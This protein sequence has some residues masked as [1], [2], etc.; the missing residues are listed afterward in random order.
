[1]KKR[2]GRVLALILA[3]SLVMANVCAA[4]ATDSQAGMT[5]S[6]VLQE[7]LQGEVKT[8][9]TDTAPDQAEAVDTQDAEQISDNEAEPEQMVENTEVSAEAVKEEQSGADAQAVTE[10]RYENE[11]VEVTVSAQSEGAIPTGAQL[12][13]VPITSNDDATKEQYKEVKEHIQAKADEEEKGIAGFLAYDITFVDAQGNEIEPNGEVKVSIDYKNATL[14]EGISE[15]D[16]KDTNVTVY[17][18]E[19]DENGEVKEVVDMSQAD[20]KIRTME[21]TDEKKVEKVEV[22]TESFSTFTIVWD[23]NN[24]GSQLRVTAHYG[25]IND[26]G[27]WEEIPKD[28]IS[29]FPDN[30]TITGPGKEIALTS[31][32]KE[33]KGY[34]FK[35]VKVND[36]NNGES[37]EKLVTSSK[38]EWWTTKYYI[39]YVKKGETQG[40]DWLS[41]EWNGTKEGDIYFVYSKDKTGLKIDSEHIMD[42]G[43]MKAVYTSNDGEPTAVSYKWLES[44]KRDGVYT[45]VEQLIFTNGK[46]NVDGDKLYPAYN[47]GDDKNLRKW[48]KVE[49]TLSDKTTVISEP[50]QVP[51]YGQLQNGG[52]ETPDL[53]KATNG[54]KNQLSNLEMLQQGGVWQTTGLGTGTD[55]DGNSRVGRDIEIIN[56]GIQNKNDYRWINDWVAKAG[57]QF[58][59]LNCEAAGALYQ[60]VLT[61]EGSSLNYWLSHRA[62]GNE[63]SKTPEYDTMYLV[64]MP[65][66]DAQNLKTQ[67][68]LK[69]YLT[70]TLG[71]SNIGQKYTQV[72]DETLYNQEGV[73]VIRVT[74]NDQEWHSLDTLQGYVPTSDVTRFFFMAGDTA[75][76]NSTVGNFLDEV[77][78][79][80]ELPPVKEDEFTFELEKNFTGLDNASIKMVKDQIGFEITAENK[81]GKKLSGK[82]LQTLFGVDAGTQGITVEDNAIVISGSAMSLDVQG[83]KI[84]YAFANQKIGKNTSYKVT[85]KERNAEIS[86]YKLTTKTQ[87]TVTYDGKETQNDDSTTVKELKGKTKATVTYTNQYKSTKNKTVNFTKIWDDADNKFFT[88]PESLEVTLT[89]SI[90]VE[91]GGKIVEKQVVKKKATVKAPT[92]KTSWDVPVYEDYNGQQVPI[93]YK[94]TEGD[95]GGDYVYEKLNN[96]IAVGGDG[97]EYKKHS[98]DGVESLESSKTT[99]QKKT[100]KAEEIKANETTGELGEPSHHKY[101]EYN[102]KTA[103]YTLNLDVTGKKGEATGVDVLFVIDTSGSM[104][105]GYM[106]KV[107]DLLAG[108]NNDIVDQIFKAQGNVN[109]VSCVG[110][111]GVDETKVSPWYTT[112][113]KAAL[114]SWIRGLYA[115]GGTNWTYAMEKAEEQFENRGG[116]NEKVVIFL[117]DG[118]PTY[119]MH[120]VKYWWGTRHEQYGEGNKTKDEYYTEAIQTVTGSSTLK[121]IPVYSVYLN[122][123]T[124]TGMRKFAEGVKGGGGKSELVDGTDLS[125]ALTGILNKVIPTYK[126]VIITDTLSDYVEFAE[127]SNPTVTVIKELANG[128]KETLPSSEYQVTVDGKKVQVSLLN[129]K[130]LE[131]G[132]TYTIQFKIKPSQAAND[133][134]AEHDGKYPHIGD[135]GTGSTSAGKEGF[136]SN[137]EANVEYKIDGKEG[138]DNAAYQKPVVQVTNHKLVYEKKWEKPADVQEP[139]ADIVLH[140]TYTDGTQKDITLTSENGYKAQEVVP[141]TKRIS[142]VTEE[143]VD[144]YTPSYNINSDGTKAVVTNSYSKIVSSSVKVVKE[145]AGDGPKSP[146]TVSLWQQRGNEEPVK[147]GDS[148]TLNE[149]GGWEHIW[150]DL[151]LSEG[152]GENEIT[153]TYAVR[154][155]NIPDNYTSGIKTEQKDGMTVV[156]ITNTYD[157]NCEDEDFYI[158]NVLQT[159]N[160]RLHKNWIDNNDEQKKRPDTL[161][162]TVNGKKFTLEKDTW[163]KELTIPKKK[164]SNYTATETLPENSPYEQQGDAVINT[165]PDGT[166]IEFT[167]KLKTTFVAVQ[168][169]WNDADIADRPTAIK[170]KLWYRENDAAEWKVYK[171]YT[172]TEENIVEDVTWKTVI[173]NLP[174]EY[175]YKVE[176]VSGLN[177]GYISNVVGNDH[178][179]VITNTLKWVVKKTDGSGN[180]LKGA[181]F[182]LK[183]DKEV[184]ATGVSETDGTISWTPAENQNLNQ[185]D[186]EYTLK[187]TKAPDGYQLSQKEWTMIFEKGLLTTFDNNEVKGTAE[188]GVV[189]TVEN[190][191]IYTLPESGGNG[192]YWYMVSGVLLMTV[193]GMLILYKNKRKEVLES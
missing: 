181:E 11:E 76:G 45:E 108:D 66:K 147:Y 148:V 160:L 13:V 57:K 101:I 159:E 37:I 140:V 114:K 52:F 120:D 77:G 130:S 192:I 172:L 36:A 88:R 78:F 134:F 111:A 146:V 68:E 38:D 151:P 91:E 14:P 97:S 118:E 121:N 16:A 110:F 98:F 58:V 117:S 44:D 109:A 143:A 105:D 82:E 104:K 15:A 177:S 86:G 67:D 10:L 119:S 137:T 188:D 43:A 54:Y 79:G 53:K 162:V 63:Q 49:A 185:L 113:Q 96:G 112:N 186:G 102:E 157:K 17:H 135:S 6:A 175:N 9:E 18:L 20:N 65:A 21:M 132:V 70:K 51:Y 107:K 92:W 4:S 40:K 184:I 133:Y 125:E 164:V 81:D 169:V 136:Y 99:E 138:S 12:Q 173:D 180:G 158:A 31:Y 131:A 123:D 170:F 154:E 34:T 183:K 190:E 161:E 178:Q 74:S 39:Q 182:E 56:T 62:R 106:K 116:S 75:S 22:L 26:G 55:G 59:E 152:Q 89:G 187:E 163:S 73:K 153:Y 124:E 72:G 7:N 103:E 61:M 126:D 174:A 47:Q 29:D 5:D 115:N 95:I 167:N 165:M 24:R 85:V 19:E 145:W 141:V 171:E 144:G 150:T 27:N 60:D 50:E 41:S 129:G 189:V 127:G 69:D 122:T 84:S 3:M 128:K 87:T 166:S 142:K 25:Y 35:D 90:F 139:T 94:V 33:I 80:Q 42:D 28:D 32:E 23:Y 8:E 71:I 191:K 149:E 46:T 193:A 100:V 1:M 83:T 168:K 176:E 64:M 179:F 30:I 93:E 2:F 155:E 156:T 48:Y